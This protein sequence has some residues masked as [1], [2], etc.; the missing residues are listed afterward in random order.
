[1]SPDLGLK[2]AYLVT[3]SLMET[4]G[5]VLFLYGLPLPGNWTATLQ[6]SSPVLYN[7]GNIVLW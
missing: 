3:Y 5:Y 4:N 1:M 6:Q 2:P 7:N